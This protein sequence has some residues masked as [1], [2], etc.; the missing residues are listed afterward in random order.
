MTRTRS[1]SDKTK[2]AKEQLN[3]ASAKVDCSFAS[4]AASATSL[5]P[6]KLARSSTFVGADIVGAVD[7][8]A[9]TILLAWGEVT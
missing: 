3:T 4:A 5:S 9:G 2:V 7:K 1:L 6:V 8:D